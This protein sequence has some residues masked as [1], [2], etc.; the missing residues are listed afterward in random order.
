MKRPALA[1]AIALLAVS[2]L[3]SA[4]GFTDIGQD[5]TPREKAEVQINGAFRLRSDWLYNFDLD[6]GLT[7]SG[8]P[9]FPVPLSDTRAQTLRRTDLRLRTDIAV[10]APG[11]GMAV[12]MRLDAIDNL[13]LGSSTEGS[14]AAATTQQPPTRAF[15]VKRAY[16]EVL[17]PFGLLSAG[18]MG[19]HWGLGMLANGGDCADCD[20]GDAADRVA[21]V[22][23]LG[24]HVFAVAYDFSATGP[25][26][27][28]ARSTR[29]V[30]LDPADDVQ[31]VTFAVMNWRN[32]LARTRRAKAKKSTFEYG[33]YGSHRWQN[34]DVPAS[35]LPIAQPTLLSRAQSM[36]RNYRATAVDGWARLTGPGFH[37]EAELAYMSATVDQASL[38]PGALLNAPVTSKQLGMA[39]ESEVGDSAGSYGVGV[40]WGYASGDKAPGFGAFPAA[41]AK[42][43]QPG[44]LEG[45]QANPPYDRTVDNFR[46][47]PDYRVDRIL[48]REIIGTVTDATYVRPHA[49]IRVFRAGPG[50]MTAS[51]AAIA[52]WAVQPASTPGNANA[53]GIELDPTLHYGSKDGFGIALEQAVL[54]PGSGLNNTAPHLQA[55]PAQ[56]WRL[57]LMYAF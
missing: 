47:H 13:S 56:L 54:F 18:R 3:A 17:T 5:L 49:R 24:G 23:P 15:R 45:A 55:K 16:G 8:Q 21:F 1:F 28:Q 29:A 50:E 38:I 51:I 2:P 37:V 25:Q 12:K 11:G 36:A 22:T 41:N 43:G 42:Y 35:Y 9:L 14:P 57:R 31:T 26:T 44:E 7:P 39:L 27:N 19:S 40:D 48:F 6:R 46:F 20:S 10:Y 52:S 34:N 4:T 30:D 33:A 32:D 53:L